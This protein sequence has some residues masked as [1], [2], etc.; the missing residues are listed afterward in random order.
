LTEHLTVGKASLDL[1]KK[2]DSNQSVIDTQRE[3][4]KG[5]IDELI[6]CAKDAESKYGTQRCFYVCVQT[7]RERLLVNVIRNQF[8]A[9]YSRPFPAYDLAL[10]H[11]DPRDEK[12]SFVWCI[13][14]K[15]TVDV[16]SQPDYIC[17]M[18][19]RQLYSFVLGFKKGTLI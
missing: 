13:P 8:Y 10:Y 15:D 17:P 6:K 1:L 9:R 2:A 11:Y 5:Y 19:Q 4:Q 14:D 12:L 3:M 16:M 18:D 7:R